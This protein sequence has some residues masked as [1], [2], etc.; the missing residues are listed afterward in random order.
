[1]PARRPCACGCGELTPERLGRGR[2]R[3]YIEGH[4]PV[5]AAPI[6]KYTRSERPAKPEAPPKLCACGCGEYFVAHRNRKW[7]DGHRPVAE[8][9]AKPEAPRKLCACGC[10]EQ[11]VGHGNRQ[12]L[13]GHQPPRIR[14]G[15]RAPRVVGLCA[16][17]CGENVVSRKRESRKPRYITNHYNEMVHREHEL[18]REAL[19]KFIE[20]WTAA[21]IIKPVQKLDVQTLRRAW[22]RITAW[23][24]FVTCPPNIVVSADPG[25]DFSHFIY[26][27]VDPRTKLVRY[28]GL[29]TTGIKRPQQHR[30]Q[31][32]RD[33]KLYKSRWIIELERCGL[34]FEIVVLEV[35]RGN[36]EE[37]CAVEKW[38]IAYGRAS[39]WPLTN[40]TDGG[41]GVGGLKKTPEQVEH[42]RNISKDIWTR[43]G[44]RARHEQT[45]M[46]EET[47]VRLS[48][49]AKARWANMSPE[50][51]EKRNEN[52]GRAAS[53]NNHKLVEEGRHPM[54]RPEVREKHR[55]AMQEIHK[56]KTTRRRVERRL[57]LRRA[58]WVALFECL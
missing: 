9:S 54:Q 2:K 15:D 55:E 37:L 42:M 38:W 3:L 32:A 44:Y 33:S 7:I 43:P 46:S 25:V 29:S 24:E 48:E 8:H 36:W 49:A 34:T 6:A 56:Q 16:C 39:G 21:G 40:L 26:G 35:T 47:K 45:M 17:G 11:V 4:R 18:R 10:G 57:R 20:R 22:R 58:L 31:K 23:T 5:D 50:E 14:R 53:I 51:R 41:D 12:W 1:M 30:S 19:A 27:L 28:V 13:D 52:A